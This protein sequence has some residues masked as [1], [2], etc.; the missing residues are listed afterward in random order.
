MN[1]P[2]H[3]DI[4]GWRGYTALGLFVAELFRTGEFLLALMR[5]YL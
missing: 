2:R 5:H 1:E 3:G 4:T